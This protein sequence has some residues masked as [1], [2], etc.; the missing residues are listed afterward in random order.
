MTGPN[1]ENLRELFERFVG[2][3]EALKAVEDFESAE[4]ILR[5]HPA[6]EPGE[7]LIAGIKSQ[8]AQTVRHRKERSFRRLANRLAP[9]AAVF[10]V[11]AV[12]GIKMFSDGGPAEGIRIKYI[13][14]SEWESEDVAADDLNLVVLTAQVDELEGEIVTLELGEDSGD[15][16]SEVTELEMELAEINSGFWEG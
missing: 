14:P 2:A 9:V 7:E 8:I 16:G 4:R 12:V 15:G 5:E 6:P 11:L 13:S 10:I 1:N 3:E